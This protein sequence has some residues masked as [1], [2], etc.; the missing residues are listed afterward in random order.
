ML[1]VVTA[2]QMQN[3]DQMAISQFGIPG[4]VLM[5]N[6]G[7]GVFQELEKLFLDL[8]QKK[9]FIFCGKG[10]NGGDGFVI[11]RHLFNLGCEVHVLLAGNFSDL[12]N[13][14]KTNA[15]TMLNLGVTTHELD[16]ENLNRHDHKLRHCD[17]IIDSV[18]G[19]G[20]N[21]P[22]TGFP[23]KVINKINT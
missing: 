13:D 7:I 3:I 2:H 16:S 22:L 9:V 1:P 4:M 5:E 12:K 11:A 18:F 17:L 6:A 15:N 21:K 10:N 20:L 14:A 23:E 8:P 19:T